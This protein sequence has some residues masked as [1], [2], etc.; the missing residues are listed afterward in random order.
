MNTASSGGLTTT[1][2]YNGLGERVKKT[3]SQVTRYFAYDEAGQLVGEYD[4]SGA[5]V[6]E[7]VWFGDIP[8]ATLRPD[9]SSGIDVYYVHTDHLNTPRRV[10]R[11]SDG[12]VIWEWLST[13]FGTI[14]ADND[15]DADSSNFAYNLRFPGQYFDDETGLHY[16]YYRTYDPSTGRYLES[17]PIGL[18]GGLNTFGYVLQN[19]LG[20]VDSLGLDAQC[21]CKSKGPTGGGGTPING[22]QPDKIC[23]YDCVCYELDC[24]GEM[25][26][27]IR[28]FEVEVSSSAQETTGVD[29]SKRCLGQRYTDDINRQTARGKQVD[30]YPSFQFRTGIEPLTISDEAVRIHE[31]LGVPLPEAQPHEICQLSPQLCKYV[32]E[33]F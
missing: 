21:T 12:E 30:P 23:K 28:V 2:A 19:P 16:N 7:T 17:D 15:P 9:G 6:Q 5:L 18:G 10:E 24:N 8:V 13:P 1:Y 3:N 25:T 22:V 20:L 32:D 14:D 26:K 11:P 27:E 29:I 31:E 4:G 33:Q